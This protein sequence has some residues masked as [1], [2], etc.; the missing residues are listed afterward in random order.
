MLKPEL[1]QSEGEEIFNPETGEILRVS[2]LRRAFWK[3]RSLLEFVRDLNNGTITL[4][5]NDYRTL[6]AT[7]VDVL[8]IFKGY[9]AKLNR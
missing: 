3:Y 2:E 4:T 7:V 9:V 5:L 8:A 6:P 1:L